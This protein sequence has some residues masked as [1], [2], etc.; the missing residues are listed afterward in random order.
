MLRRRE[1]V[2]LAAAGATGAAALHMAGGAVPAAPAP[3]R[4]RAL[5]KLG[6]QN[7][8]TDTKRLQ[9]FARHGVKNV[10]GYPEAAVGRAYASAEELVA[11]KERAAKW[12]V[13]I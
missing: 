2:S 1:F 13:R 8:P 11:L 12:G 9:F 5:M 6:C 3:Q 7:S 10:C 4:K